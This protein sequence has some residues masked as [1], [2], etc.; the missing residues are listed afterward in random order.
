MEPAECERAEVDAPDVIVDFFQAHLL[1]GADGGNSDRVRVPADDS[2][3]GYQT[4]I[5]DALRAYL[6]KASPSMDEGTLRRV[7][8][9]EIRKAGRLRALPCQLEAIVRRA[10]QGR[11]EV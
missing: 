11:T 5:N 2:G 8:R 4:M 10:D 9:E 1:P 7:I 3:R 6:G